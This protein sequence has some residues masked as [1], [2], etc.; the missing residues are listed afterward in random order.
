M[1]DKEFLTW[2]YFRLINVYHENPNCDFC[3]KL[4]AIVDA[5]PPDNL[6]MFLKNEMEEK[7]VR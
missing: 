1:K 6:N 2:L 7:Y 4:A 5:M 3:Y